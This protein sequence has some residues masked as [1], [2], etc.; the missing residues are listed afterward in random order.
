[1]R[2]N[3]K[4]KI[5]KRQVIR[6]FLYIVGIVAVV[7]LAQFLTLTDIEKSVIRRVSYIDYADIDYQVFY[8]SDPTNAITGNT[9]LASTIDH[10]IA[11]FSYDMEYSENV[12]GEYSYD[13]KARLIVTDP[14]DS[15]NIYWQNEYVLSETQTGTFN[16]VN[17]YELID[18]VSIDYPYFVQEYL[19]FSNNL[20][21]E[22][23]G[24]L[25]I[26]TTVFSNGRYHSLKDLSNTST[27]KI[28]IPLDSSSINI[29]ETYE[30]LTDERIVEESIDRTREAILTKIL[31]GICWLV[32]I[33]LLS[34]FI[35]SYFENRKKN[36]SYH[37]KLES[38]LRRY[39]NIIVDIAKMPSLTG[40]N[41]IKVRSFEELCDAQASLH[42]PINFYLDEQNECAIFI[43]ILNNM[44]WEYI[45]KNTD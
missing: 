40:L 45:L 31:A 19:N 1:M 35:Y 24:T 9:F 22:L 44:A 11:T 43:V 6:Y 21:L 42:Q 13:T 33:I 23:K 14:A 17:G 12:S 28:T 26:E 7:V 30:L 18:E 38:I 15:A 29:D 32:A 2:S 37:R 36:M 8:Q 16:S 4:V 34:C 20:G 3:G 27:F 41:I 10:I 39:N 5:N 25:E